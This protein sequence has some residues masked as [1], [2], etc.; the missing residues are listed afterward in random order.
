MDFIKDPDLDAQTQP[1][2]NQSDAVCFYIFRIVSEN[3][4]KRTKPTKSVSASL[5]LIT[6]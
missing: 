3:A 5:T 4:T 2:H 6:L 1:D